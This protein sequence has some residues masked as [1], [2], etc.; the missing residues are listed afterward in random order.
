MT[1][2]KVEEASDINEFHH[3][4]RRPA[5]DVH[6]LPGIKRDSL[7]SIPKFVDPNYIAIFNKDKI[8][9]Y[10]ANRTTIIISCGTIL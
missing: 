4:V 6:I 1:N 9:T 7:H 2:G 5:K 8:S 10:N 3:D